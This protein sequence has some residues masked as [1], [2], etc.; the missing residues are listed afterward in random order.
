MPRAAAKT[1]RKEER[2][3]SILVSSPVH[4]YEDFLESIYALLETF[5]Y[6]VLMSHKGTVPIDPELS[7]MSNCLQAVGS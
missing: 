3:L 1:K 4:G 7:A 2:Q 5:G 6:D